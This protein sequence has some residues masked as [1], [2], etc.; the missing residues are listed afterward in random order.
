VSICFLLYISEMG[1]SNRMCCLAFGG[2][3]VSWAAVMGFDLLPSLKVGN[4]CAVVCVRVSR[5]W[6]YRGGTDDGPIQHVDLVL[7]DEKVV[8]YGSISSYASGVTTVL[9]LLLSVC[10]SHY[11]IIWKCSCDPDSGV[12]TGEQKWRPRVRL[13]RRMA[14]M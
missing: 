1:I 9:F 2:C 11:I 4:M 8:C 13:W 5:K 10:S 14:S 7:V 12:S 3:S 6:E